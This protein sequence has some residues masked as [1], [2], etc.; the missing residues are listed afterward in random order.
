MVGADAAAGQDEVQ[1]E[2]QDEVRA[3]RLEEVRSFFDVWSLFHKVILGDHSSH[4]GAYRALAA[5]LSG[6]PPFRFL[7]LGCGDACGTAWALSG[8]AISS[9][10][11][12]DLSSVALGLARLNLEKATCPKEFLDEDFSLAVAR[13]QERFD[14]VWIG[15]SLHHLPGEAK[16]AFLADVRRLLVP[17]GVLGVYDPFRSEG[18]G[19]EAFHLSLIHI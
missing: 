9:Y 2:E 12:V 10:V 8:K 14:V 4:M 13:P 18:E 19:R 7:D 17:G 6:R 15:L 3:R 11:G 1:D 5:L 16:G